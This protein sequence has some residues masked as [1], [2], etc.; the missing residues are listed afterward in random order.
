MHA[1]DLIPR[2]LPR[3]GQ[4]TSYRAGDDGDFEAGWPGGRFRD[5]GD[6]TV[7][8]FATGLMWV[9]DVGADPGAPF[10][11][12]VNWDNAID[13]CL[14]LNYAGYDDWRLPNAKEPNRGQ[15]NHGSARAED[16]N[17]F[18]N[19]PRSARHAA[20]TITITTT[21]TTT[22]TGWWRL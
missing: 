13:N 22:T 7:T 4:T 6:G 18:G 20:I 19:R 9:Q 1:K 10:N 5:N 21:T 12:A 15:S 17:R 14:A 8:D 16:R 3:T 11:A 2:E